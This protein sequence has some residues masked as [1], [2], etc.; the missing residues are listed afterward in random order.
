MR[1]AISDRPAPL[2]TTPDVI[3]ARI[4]PYRS[5][6]TASYADRPW[7]N[8]NEND[9]VIYS[10]LANYDLSGLYATVHKKK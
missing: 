9:T 6:D 10:D 5:T 2:P 4:V 3:Y 7:N 1:D 8:L